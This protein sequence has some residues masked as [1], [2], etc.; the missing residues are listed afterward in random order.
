MHECRAIAERQTLVLGEVITM[1]SKSDER[2]SK[3]NW[4]Q[5]ITLQVYGAFSG[6]TTYS[7]IARM[8][9]GSITFLHIPQPYSASKALCN[10]LEGKGG[11]FLATPDDGDEGDSDEMSEND[12]GGIY[13]ALV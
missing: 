8:E 12:P 6:T 9:L 3:H 4:L 2:G 11:L 1:Y 13:G 7:S 5:S 10:L